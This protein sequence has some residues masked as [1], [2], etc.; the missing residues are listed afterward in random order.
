MNEGIT[1]SSKSSKQNHALFCLYRRCPRHS[2][3]WEQAVAYS[4]STSV[5]SVFDS[6]L[7]V[8]KDFEG[9]LI[10]PG[11]N[12]KIVGLMIEQAT[13]ERLGVAPLVL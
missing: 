12:E 3:I 6:L 11:Y 9:T 13:A 4:G 5:W 8:G 2:C 1:F 7:P 10:K